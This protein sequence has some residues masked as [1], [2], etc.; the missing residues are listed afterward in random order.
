MPAARCCLLPA[1]CSNIPCARGFC[2]C[3]RLTKIRVLAPTKILWSKACGKPGAGRG[4][5][6]WPCGDPC[7]PDGRPPVACGLSHEQ[8]VLRRLATATCR[9]SARL[10]LE[11]GQFRSIFGGGTRL[12]VA[13][14]LCLI[15]C[16]GLFRFSYAKRV[17]LELL[18]TLFCKTRQKYLCCR[19]RGVVETE[20]VDFCA[21]DT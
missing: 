1:P 21:A 9:L 6:R 2:C 4:R 16:L 17:Y 19:M 12:E 11:R 20:V 5:G 18:N 8:I 7:P 13:A 3:Y 10:G 15:I 14:I